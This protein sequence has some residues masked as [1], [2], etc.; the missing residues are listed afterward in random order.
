MSERHPAVARALG[1]FQVGHL[2]PNLAKIA[3]P[4][5]VLAHELASMLP[6]SPDLTH[7]LHY[8]LTAKDNA[9]RAALDVLP[10]GYSLAA[11][12]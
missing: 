4:F 3:A 8:L 2:P 5:V 12:A 7:A 1:H 10:A 9:V 6:D 11:T